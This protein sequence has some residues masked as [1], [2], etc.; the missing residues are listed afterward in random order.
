MY[1]IR[2]CPARV[3]DEF[4][5]A[6]QEFGEAEAKNDADHRLYILE[7][8]HVL[9]EYTYFRISALISRR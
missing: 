1:P 5:G 2:L 4:Y 7:G 6:L 9:T 8:L 3:L